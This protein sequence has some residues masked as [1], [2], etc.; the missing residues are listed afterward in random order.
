MVIDPNVM[1]ELRGDVMTKGDQVVL[2]AG[3]RPIAF[4]LHIKV[5]W[6]DPLCSLFRFLLV[7]GRDLLGIGF[8]SGC[9]F[10][11]CL[12]LLKLAR[13]CEHAHHAEAVEPARCG[14]EIYRALAQQL[15]PGDLLN[16][17]ARGQQVANTSAESQADQDGDEDAQGININVG[18]C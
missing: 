8:R 13:R 10:R 7:V 14:V 4:D 3:D 11:Q 1:V 15:I 9:F 12:G 5:G 2:A 17:H 18:Q 6:L 16:M